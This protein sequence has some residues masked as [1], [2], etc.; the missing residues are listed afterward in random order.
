MNFNRTA[1]EG[2]LV[3]CE[4]IREATFRDVGKEILSDQH[5]NFRDVP[6]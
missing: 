2:V 1:G 4:L 5:P 6:K 3:L